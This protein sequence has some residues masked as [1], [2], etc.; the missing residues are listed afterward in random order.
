MKKNSSSNIRGLFVDYALNIRR[1]V[2]GKFFAMCRWTL[3]LV[4]NMYTILL[5]F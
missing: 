2:I 5:Y 1:M 4:H 3:T